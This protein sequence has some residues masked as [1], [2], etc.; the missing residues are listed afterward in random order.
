MSSDEDITEFY[1]TGQIL[2]TIVK[3]LNC[4]DIINLYLSGSTGELENEQ[5]QRIMTIKYDEKSLL[6]LKTHY[7]DLLVQSLLYSGLTYREIYANNINLN[8]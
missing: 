2:E 4:H 7:T 6:A 3:F 8:Y 1:I 5:W